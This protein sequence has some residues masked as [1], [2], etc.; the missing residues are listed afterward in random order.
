M[1]KEDNYTPNGVARAP[2]Q[3]EVI[4]DAAEK[5]KVWHTQMQA[6]ALGNQPHPQS[7]DSLR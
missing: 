4:D 2:S 1:K 3:I 7:S 6:G 5:R